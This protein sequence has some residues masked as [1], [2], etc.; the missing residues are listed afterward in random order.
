MY[1]DGGCIESR[2]IGCSSVSIYLGHFKSAHG[3][4][5]CPALRLVHLGIYNQSYPSRLLEL[6]PIFS[7][8]TFP[9]H[10]AVFCLKKKKSLVIHSLFIESFDEYPHRMIH[11]SS[12]EIQVFD[13]GW[14]LSGLRYRFRPSFFAWKKCGMFFRIRLGCWDGQSFLKTFR[15]P[16][17]HI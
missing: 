17:R 1:N 10:M 2:R 15:F 16:L 14:E 4:N 3:K 6:I 12:H 7:E 9:V 11:F 13:L 5:V 8:G